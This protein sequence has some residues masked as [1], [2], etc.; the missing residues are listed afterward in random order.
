VAH[1]WNRS[2]GYWNSIRLLIGHLAGTAVM[3]VSLFTI[4]WGLATLLGWFNTIHPFPVPIF[5]FVTKLEVVLVYVDTASCAIV[6]LG[7]TWHFLKEI[8]P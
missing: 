3:F 1:E 8:F 6:L 4:A 2:G 5:A 7:G